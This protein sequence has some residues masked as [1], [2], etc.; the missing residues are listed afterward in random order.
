MYDSFAFRPL[1]WFREEKESNKEK[2]LDKQ[3]QSSY[4]SIKRPS[5]NAVVGSNFGGLGIY[6]SEK[7]RDLRYR[8]QQYDDDS[9]QS[10]SEH[11]PFHRDIFNNGHK[12]SINNRLLV[13]YSP[14]RY[15]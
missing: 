11:V 7:I 9:V 1:E 12:V 15:T 4:N 2:G 3:T 13:S 10:D 14:H 8:S 5:G 6:K